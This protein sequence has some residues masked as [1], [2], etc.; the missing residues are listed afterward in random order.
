MAITTDDFDKVWASTSPLTPYEFSESNYKEGWNFVGATPPSRQMWDFLQKNNDEKMKFLLNNDDTVFENS[1]QYTDDKIAPIGTVVSQSITT[2]QTL[3]A[4]TATDLGS[5]SLSEG[6]WVVTGHIRYSTIIAGR[7]FI[8]LNDSV[9]I[10]ADVD[11]TVNHY[12]NVANSSTLALNTTRIFVLSQ[13]TTIYLVGYVTASC[14][15]GSCCL[16]AVRII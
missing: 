12:S 16:T 3:S 8:G 11:G 4:D 9:H 2:S 6:T 15:T 5:I 1:K 13:P 10:T 14:L 7:Q